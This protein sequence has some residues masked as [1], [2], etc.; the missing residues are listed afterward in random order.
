MGEPEDS[1]QQIR[2]RK[3]A[4]NEVKWKKNVKSF[5]YNSGKCKIRKGQVRER[6]IK[7]GCTEK[8]KINK[9]QTLFDPGERTKICEAFWAMNSKVRR[10]DYIAN[11][12]MKLEKKRATTEGPSK[13]KYSLKYFLKNGTGEKV[14]VCQRFFLDTLDITERMVDYTM[15]KKSAA[16]ATAPVERVAKNKTSDET[17]DHIKAHINS[18]SRVESH[19]CRA[20]TKREYL[21]PSLNIRQMFRLYKEKCEQEG[22]ACVKESVYR[23]IFNTGF[24]LG[25]HV[26]SKDVCDFCARYALI[27]SPSPQDVMEHESHIRRKELA[28]KSKEEDKRNV[29]NQNTF[30]IAEFDLQQV[31]TCPKLNVA[32]AYYLRKLNFYN[33]TVLDLQDN[34]GHCFCWSEFESNRGTNDIASAL[35]RWLLQQDARG[36]SKVILFSDTCGGQNRNRIFLTALIVFLDNASSITCIEHKFFERGHSKMEADSMHSAIARQFEHK[37]IYLPSGYMACM[38]SANKKKPYTVTELKHEDVFDFDFINKKYM[39]QDAFNGIMK[40]HHILCQKEDGN[41]TVKFAEEIGGEWEVKSYRKRGIAAGCFKK[42]IIPK[43]YKTPCGIDK[44]K[45][46]D[47]TKLMA[48]LPNDCQPFYQTVVKS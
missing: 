7:A 44:D 15:K 2:S 12:V 42:L 19:Y 22:R 40:I 28:R 31:M 48:F 18:F 21:D 16:V 33:F 6:S 38:A 25:F 5:L 35:W 3:K 4:R 34:Q 41:T 27:Q 32:S 20:D 1:P 39:K 36:L 23:N 17:I 43:A 8:C 29:S 45:K 9:C 47:L 37:D 24:N 30:T 46:S 26:P 14:K 13:R 11:N 10:Q